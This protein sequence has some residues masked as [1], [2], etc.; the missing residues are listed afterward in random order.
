MWIWQF[1]VIRSGAGVAS[2]CITH[3]ISLRQADQRSQP[4]TD[5][6]CRTWWL[7]DL[8]NWS[9]GGHRRAHRAA[10]LTELQSQW[11]NTAHHHSGIGLMTPQAVHYGTASA[12]KYPWPL[13]AVNS[14]GELV[15]IRNAEVR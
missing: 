11:Y 7:L 10:L 4:E 8:P 13:H 15:P 12:I 9:A 14:G 3:L 2:D 6:W 5:R 1:A